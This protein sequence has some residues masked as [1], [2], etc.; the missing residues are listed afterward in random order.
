MIH[1]L[2][3]QTPRAMIAAGGLC[4]GD[5]FAAVKAGEAF[6]DFKKARG[7]HISL[8]DYGSK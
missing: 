6:V 8:I 5:F 4:G 3:V 2:A 7:L 1:V